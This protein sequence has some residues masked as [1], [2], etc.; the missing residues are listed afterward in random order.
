MPGEIRRVI[1]NFASLVV[2]NAFVRTVSFIATLY[3]ARELGPADFGQ[4]SFGLAVALAFSS[5]VNFGLDSLVVREVARD[6]EG[7]AALLGDALILKMF[8]L[9]LTVLVVLLFLLTDPEAVFLFLFLT[10]YSVLHS[11]L[12]LFCAVFR[13]LERM[14]FQTFFLSTQILLIAVGSIIAVYL[15]GEATLVAAT[16]L[17]TTA[18]VLGGSYIL[19]LRKGLRPHYRWQPTAW[20][21]L[22]RTVLPF[23]LT[24]VGLAIYDRQA[25]VFIILLCGE[26]AAGWFNAAFSFI[27]VL[28]NIPTIVVNTLFPLLSRRAQD[29]RRSAVAICQA[30]LKYT[31]MVSFPLATGLFVLAPSLIPLLFGEEYY[32]SVRLLYLIAPSL[33]FIFLTVIL[34]G[35]LQATD[36]QRACAAG[37]WSALFVAT[38]GCLAVTWLWGYQA[39]TLAYT[40]SHLLLAGVLFWLVTRVVG[41]VDL[42][43]VFVRPAVAS[44][45]MGLVA[46]LGR[47]WPLVLLILVA[48]FC[49]G[50]VLLVVGAVGRREW[51]LWRSAWRG[52]RWGGK[53]DEVA[54]PDLEGQLS[55]GSYLPEG[56]RLL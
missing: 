54:G 9:P 39:G 41:R 11:Y 6:G 27:P 40:L 23:G 1:K 22:W 55:T 45:A 29:D 42:R 52:W 19:L 56:D 10:G 37:M 30:A 17:F 12:L 31:N 16:Y 34:V 2:G 44:A 13:G 26:A 15:T 8:T 7:A 35:V 28:V 24:I 50:A 51:A 14:E 4:L 25:I 38:P 48:S 46:Y 53:A 3:L 21:R 5:L 33:P 20:R 36:R 49:Y 47:G 18:V 43:E 32:N